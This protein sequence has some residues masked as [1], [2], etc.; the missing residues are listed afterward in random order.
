MADFSNGGRVRGFQGTLAVNRALFSID[1][2]PWTDDH[3]GLSPAD[4]RP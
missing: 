4:Y 3:A 1:S 2:R